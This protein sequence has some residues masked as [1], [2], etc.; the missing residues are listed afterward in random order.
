[1][2]PKWAKRM[3][4]LLA[5]NGILICLEFP[6][7]KPASSG[8]PPF[9]LP[10]LVH[11]ELFR[12]PGAEIMYDSGGKVVA[13]GRAV[14]DKALVKVAHWKPERTYKVGIV[15]GEVTDRVSVWKHK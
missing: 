9:S 5:P 1:M 3:A 15:N 14:S 11:E 8:G 13:T 12:Y 2:R 6:T 4:Q 7:H 10:S